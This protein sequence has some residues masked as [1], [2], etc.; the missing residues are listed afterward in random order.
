MKNTN[1]PVW[2]Q[3]KPN[4]PDEQISETI[5]S[6]VVVVGSGNA[7]LLA[8]TAA[9]YEG[10]SVSVI[11]QQ[12]EKTF[13]VYG[14]PDIG[15]INSKWAAEHGYPHIDEDAFVAEWQHRTVNRSDPRIIKKFAHHSG[16][17]LDWLFTLMDPK[18]REMATG[19]AYRDPED[20]YNDVSGYKSWLGTCTVFTFK[21]G[22]REL[23]AN[24]EAHGA[25]WYWGQTGRVLV[26][27]PDGRV[28]GCIAESRAE[29][30]KYTKYLARKG[31]IL[32]AGD[33]GANH[34][35]FVN[36][37]QEIVQQ[38][39]SYG[40]ST[41]KLRTAMGRN[42]D[43]QKMAIWAG[44]SMEPGPYASVYPTAFPPSMT[45]DPMFGWG[46]GMRGT[47]FLRL[48]QEGKRYCDEGI[49]GIY[50]CVHRSIRM[51][52]GIYYSVYDS[53]WPEYLFTQCNE[54]FMMAKSMEEIEGMKVC[55]KELEKLGHA[56]V[57]FKPMGNTVEA[58]EPDKASHFA[59]NTLEELADRMG[60][61]EEVRQNFLASIAR[62]NEMC[63]QHKDEDFGKDPRLLMPIDKPPYYASKAVIVR[64][65]TGLVT[66]NGVIT[67]DN[68]AVLDKQYKPIPGLFASGTN[69]GGKFFIQYS[70]VL[71]GMNIGSAMT[72]GMLAGRHVAGLESVEPQ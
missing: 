60:L 58:C 26:Q 22:V 24:A 10:A 2:A 51:G 20:C 41:D 11:E 42:G 49:M 50:G 48:T 62:Y 52:P 70:S 54:H 38:Y 31:V 35:M 36:L 71:S 44:G 47:S 37:Y 8:A 7:G 68:Q 39:E 55:Y 28:I 9:A 64:P 15:T 56:R 65:D 72:L 13:S 5:I 27:R 12:R 18:H 57:D 6:D 17:M 4:I 1:Y 45:D 3:D 61:T 66:L 53:Q 32:T 19:Y 34:E 29:P 23:I 14:V 30:G 63:Y 69:G 25:K 16:E 40:L 21:E 43:G 33:W 59:A 67:D 46:G